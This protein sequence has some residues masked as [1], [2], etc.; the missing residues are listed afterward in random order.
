MT[1]CYYVFEHNTD[2]NS[3]IFNAEMIRLSKCG[4][5]FLNEARVIKASLEAALKR[6]LAEMAAVGLLGEKNMASESKN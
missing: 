3:Y 1:Y 2:I 4:T 5:Q 6:T